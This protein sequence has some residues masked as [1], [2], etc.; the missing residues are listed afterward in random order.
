MT[1]R[2]IVGSLPAPPRF[3]KTNHPPARRPQHPPHLAQQ[4][5]RI[6]GHFQRVNHQD[7]VDGGIRQ[8]QRKLID[9]CCE[10]WARRRPLQHALRGRHEGDAALRVLAKQA[11]IRGG[12]AQAEH[13]LATGGRPARMNAAID[14]PPCHDTEAL[15]IEIAEVDDID[16]H[17]HNLTRRSSV[18]LAE[19]GIAWEALTPYF[20]PIWGSPA[21]RH[22]RS[23]EISWPAKFSC[24]P[25]SPIIS[26]T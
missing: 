25:A 15:R 19:Y 22:I 2:R 9:Q 7:A 20:M 26:A 18:R 5:L 16:G 10:G 6:V 8:R 4:P 3:R 11:E 13:P 24:F 1:E 23:T 17:G 21:S 12:I 14:Q